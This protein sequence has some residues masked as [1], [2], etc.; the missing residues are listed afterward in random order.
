MKKLFVLLLALTVLAGAVFA[1]ATVNGYIR[2]IGTIKEDGT[3]SDAYRLRLNLSWKSEDGNVSFAARIQ[4]DVLVG[5]SAP[6]YAYGTIKLADGKVAISG[7]KLWNFDYDLSSTGSDYAATGNVANGGWY[8]GT[9]G[10]LFQFMPVEALSIGLLADPD[11]ADLGIG[12][13]G[14]NAKYAIEGVGDILLASKFADPFD[15]SF[16]SATFKFTG[17]EGLVA[18]V[19]YKGLATNGVFGFFSYEK[20]ALYVEV[21]PEMNFDT[22]LTYVEALVKYTMDKVAIAGLFGYDSLGTTLGDEI[23]FG[24]ELYYTVGKGQLVVCAQYGDVTGFAL[25]LVVKVSF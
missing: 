13:F 23:W 22:D 16:L 1:Q 17:V 18:A 10:M 5:F 3:F 25:P 11:G 6:N 24:G 20:D 8:L 2:T 21:A 7:G 19:G 14:L 9:T 12:Q 15:T 4:N